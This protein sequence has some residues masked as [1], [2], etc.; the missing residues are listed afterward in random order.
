MVSNISN[1]FF[2][3]TVKRGVYG[4]LDVKQQFSRLIQLFIKN[5]SPELAKTFL[6]KAFQI[7]HEYQRPFIAQ[8]L[9]RLLIKRKQFE[10]ADEWILKAIKIVELYTFYDTRGQV[11]KSQL[12]EK[13]KAKANILECIIIARQVSISSTF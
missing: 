8:T 12:E 10:E 7:L 11:F 5:K 3:A 9:A 1:N 6:E 4:E 2:T 13:T